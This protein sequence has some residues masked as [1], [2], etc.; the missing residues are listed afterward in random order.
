MPFRLYPLAGKSFPA[1]RKRAPSAL[2]RFSKGK[3]RRLDKA[4][5]VKKVHLLD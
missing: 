5:R 4:G 1:A 2:Y 3:R